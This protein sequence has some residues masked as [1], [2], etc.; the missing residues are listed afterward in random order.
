MQWSGEWPQS[1]VSLP[2]VCPTS[3]QTAFGLWSS[4]GGCGGAV[5]CI[6]WWW[7]ASLHST[8]M[9]HSWTPFFL[10]RWSRGKLQRCWGSRFSLF[11]PL[12]ENFCDPIEVL[13]NTLQYVNISNQCTEHLKIIQSCMSIYLNKIL[14][15]FWKE[16]LSYLVP[17]IFK[18]LLTLSNVP[19][20]ANMTAFLE[21][22]LHK[23]IEAVYM[24][25]FKIF[26]WS[27]LSYFHE[28]SYSINMK[29]LKIFT[30][31]YLNS[32]YETKLFTPN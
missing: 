25:L 16:C 21:T 15:G 26:A 7:A 31:N 8:H 27:S 11:S 29:L 4:L 5:P 12:K 17:E 28:T 18:R 10:S 2:L 1:E 24:Q 22:Y 13:A 3:A 19:G 30:R 6:A 14:I 20:E 32:W 9:L 23:T